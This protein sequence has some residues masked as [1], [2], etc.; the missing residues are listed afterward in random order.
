MY[1]NKIDHLLK[2]AAFDRHQ[3]ET[4][5]S[6]MRDYYLFS[7][8]K[9]LRS[10]FPNTNHEKHLNLLKQ[11]FNFSHNQF[12]HLKHLAGWQNFSLFHLPIRWDFFR[13][14]LINF[15]DHLNSIKS[16]NRFL[17]NSLELDSAAKRLA[18]TKLKVHERAFFCE[19][20]KDFLLHDK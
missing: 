14:F 11:S 18:I 16:K 20:I 13:V 19:T 5:L 3:A 6:I 8:W 4:S 17:K 15:Y 9:C 2:L 12:F 1:Q 10:T 7:D